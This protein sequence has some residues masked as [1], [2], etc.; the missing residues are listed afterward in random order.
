MLHVVQPVATEQVCYCAVANQL[1]LGDCER[2]SGYCS[3]LIQQLG[4][5]L[6]HRSAG[7]TLALKGFGESTSIHRLPT[8]AQNSGSSIRSAQS[9]SSSIRDA[10]GRLRAKP[11]IDSSKMDRNFRCGCH[12]GRPCDCSR[13]TAAKKSL[14]DRIFILDGSRPLCAFV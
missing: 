8:A 2:R 1:L 12:A 14:A 13:G 7:T 5:D 3:E 4:F 9:Q 6:H 11:K 10:P